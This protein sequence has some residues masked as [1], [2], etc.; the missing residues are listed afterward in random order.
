[1]KTKVIAALAVTAILILATL[2]A[3]NNKRRPSV[4]L[5]DG[6]LKTYTNTKHG[7]SLNYPITSQLFDEDNDD[8]L[9]AP[10]ELPQIV[11]I[12]LPEQYPS[13]R[14]NKTNLHYL[15]EI[16]LGPFDERLIAPETLAA[17]EAYRSEIRGSNKTYTISLDGVDAQ[18][19][20]QSVLRA[21]EMVRDSFI[22]M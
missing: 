20:P 4:S 9:A 11:R 8:Q 7:F 19:V 1:M 6:N 10:V 16:S 22:A 14:N 17:T 5:D 21:F 2:V 15:I 3:T 12:V 13:Y 18:E